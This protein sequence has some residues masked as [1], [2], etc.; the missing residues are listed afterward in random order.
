MKIVTWK[1]LWKFSKFENRNFDGIYRQILSFGSFCVEIKEKWMKNARNLRFFTWKIENLENF[2]KRKIRYNKK[3]CKRVF[4]V[5]ALSVLTC[6]LMDL[7]FI[8]WF[9][10]ELNRVTC[11]LDWNDYLQRISVVW[12]LFK[13][14]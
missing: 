2:M 14:Q 3:L 6:I 7:S 11:D 1:S 5:I 12:M 8:C 13:I 9:L 10:Y 4:L